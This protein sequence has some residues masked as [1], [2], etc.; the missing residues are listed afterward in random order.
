MKRWVSRI[1]TAVIREGAH[2]YTLLLLLVFAGTIAGT[3]LFLELTGYPQIGGGG[4]HI[5][6]VL[7]GGLL[8]FAACLILLIISNRWALTLG[9]ILGGIGMGFF[10][11]EVGKFITETNDYFFPAAA[12]IIYAFFLL[13]LLLYLQIRKPRIR[14]SRTELYRVLDQLSELLDSDLQEEELLEAHKRLETVIDNE[15]NPALRQL[16]DALLSYLNSP[17]IM[18][19]PGSRNRFDRF[20]QSVESWRNSWLTSRKLRWLLIVG[21]VSIA[22]VSTLNLLRFS[23]GSARPEQLELLLIQ[24][25]ENK[26]VTGL[27]SLNFFLVQMGVQAT[28]G[29]LLLAAAVLMILRKDQQ[30]HF[31]AFYGLLLNLTIGNVLLFYFEQFSSIILASLQFLLL[32]EVLDF[33]ERVSRKHSARQLPDGIENGC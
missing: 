25:I 11:D 20:L 7:W 14:D 5:A 21:L 1:P 24:L 31:Y 10:M 16:A 17:I 6:H 23:L 32:L 12:P 28:S 8:L 30:A 22:L 15:Q 2:S 27:T 3:R 26:P 13:T 33:R 4:L 18:L 9:S 19:A 29:L